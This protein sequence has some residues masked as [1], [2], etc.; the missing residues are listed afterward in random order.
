VIP[1][2]YFDAFA[3][4]KY[5]NRNRAQRFLIRRFVEHVHA[6]FLT[7]CPV[8]RVLEVGCGEGFLLG[9]L[10]QKLPDI[11]FVG[12][13]LDTDDVTRLD[14]RFSGVKAHTGSVYE[15]DFLRHSHAEFDLIICA[16]M[17]E[18]VDDPLR[19]LDSMLSLGPK[20]LLL[21]VPHEPWFML[22][23]LLRGKNITRLGNDPEHV[24]HWGPGSFQKMLSTRLDVLELRRSY[25]WL[26][27][28]SAPK[29]HAR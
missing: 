9:Y 7:A 11:E 23:N 14:A 29:A 27:T 3:T 25:P 15:L 1:D 8:K 21:T 16:E 6:L 2:S 26:L 4:A 12:V 19:A 20:H 18:H 24:N 13:D 10:S 5:Q 17:L 22:S 28:L